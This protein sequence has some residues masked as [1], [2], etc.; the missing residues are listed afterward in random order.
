MSV[1][2]SH[3]QQNTCMRTHTHTHTQLF[4]GSMDFVSRYKKKH[5]PTNTYLL[6]PSTTIHGILPVWSTCLTIFPQSLSKFSLVYLLAWHSPLHTPYISSPNHCLL[7]H[8]TCQYHR[9]LFR[10]STEIILS[11]PS[12]SLNPLLG[13]LSCSFT[14]HIHLTIFISACWSSTSFFFFMGQVSLPCATILCTQ[15]L[16]NHPLTFNDISLLVSNGTNCLNLFHP[17]RI[18]FSTAAFSIYV[19]SQYVT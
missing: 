5:S 3:Y 16:Y 10:C 14:P 11:N 15:P 17:I 19:Y 18:L 7:F 1:E 13:N 6:H 9:S 12:L 2:R 8:N 4:Y